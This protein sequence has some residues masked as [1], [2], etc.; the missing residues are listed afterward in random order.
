MPRSETEVVDTSAQ[1]THD[2]TLYPKAAKGQG[3]AAPSRRTPKTAQFYKQW[4]VVHMFAACPLRAA[5][6]LELLGIQA[7]RRRPDRC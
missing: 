1:G 2:V 6:P 5:E 4:Q 7:P 3:K